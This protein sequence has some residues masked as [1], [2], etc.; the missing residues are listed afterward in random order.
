MTESSKP[1][2]RRAFNAYRHGLTG[3]VVVILPFEQ[4]AYEKHCD[5]IHQSLAP[6]GAMETDLV[7]S[8]ADD[9]WRLKRAAAIE[10]NIYTIGL[11]KPDKL[12]TGHEQS[13][14]ALA[15]ART[16]LEHGGDLALLSLYEA[17]LQRKVERNLALLRQLQQDRRAALREAVETAAILPE[18]E[19]F[20]ESVRPP[21][22]VC[23]SAQFAVLVRHQRRLLNVSPAARP[24]QKCSPIP[25]SF[26]P[27]GRS[28]C[29]TWR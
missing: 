13:D 16:F 5:G 9:R 15:M 7:Q 10:A 2:D 12:H 8:I 1:R 17:R 25:G 4:A 24:P 20:P 11:T 18:T 14:A 26:G 21:E 23:S 6:L 19:E 28:S 3:Q 29:E 27:S 22:F